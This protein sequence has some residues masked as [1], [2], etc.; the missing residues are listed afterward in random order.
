MTL[1]PYTSTATVDSGGTH[2]AISLTSDGNSFISFINPNAWKVDYTGSGSLNQLIFNPEATDATAGNTTEPVDTTSGF[3]SRPGIVFDNRPPTVGFPF[4]VGSTTGVSA[5]DISGAYSNQAPPPA[6]VGNHFYTLT[7]NIAS[8]ALTNGG[9]TFG[10]DRDEADA[11]GSAGTV[12]GNY[13]D[14]LGQGVLIPEGTVADGGMTFQAVTSGGTFSGKFTNQIG[15]GYT[16][17]DGFG[18]LNAEAA[19]NDGGTTL[20]K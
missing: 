8:G 10:Q 18:F 12:G 7:I 4:A 17:L 6:L 19:V 5:S 16:P 20:K 2:L 15:H 14:L 9:F 1:D 13:G 11:F 3:T